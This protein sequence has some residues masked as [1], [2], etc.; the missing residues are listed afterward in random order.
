M[1]EVREDGKIEILFNTTNI[2]KFIHHISGVSN[3]VATIHH[4]SKNSGLDVFPPLETDGLPIGFENEQGNI[5]VTPNDISDWIF[6]K[7]FEDFIVGLTQSLIEA[8]SLLRLHALTERTAVQPIKTPEEFETEMRNIHTKGPKMNFPQL[9][10]AIE[11]MTGGILPLRDEILSVNQTRN[12]L[13]HKNGIAASAFSLRY[14]EMRMIVSKDGEL[15]RLTKQ[16]KKQGLTGDQLYMQNTPAARTFADGEKIALD[17]DVFKDVTYTGILFIHELISKLPLPDEIKQQI[18][19]PF[20][21]QL[22]VGP[23]S[24]A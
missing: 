18:V 22:A 4:L 5:H 3:V 20:K 15:I 13:V 1:Y 8:Y 10:D 23:A 2:L 6:R 7:S 16:I 17:A 9:I 24:G 11:E 19:R 21:I 14:I 12:C